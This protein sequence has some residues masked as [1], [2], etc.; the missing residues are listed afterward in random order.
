LVFW[1][2]FADQLRYIWFHLLERLR[3]IFHFLLVLLLTLR[4]IR[5][6]LTFL[7]SKC[8]STCFWIIEFAMEILHMPWYSV[9]STLRFQAE[10]AL[11]RH[12]S[13]EIMFFDWLLLLFLVVR[14]LDLLVFEKFLKLQ[15]YVRRP[16]GWFKFHLTLNLASKALFPKVWHLKMIINTIKFKYKLI[17]LPGHERLMTGNI[18]FWH[19]SLA[20]QLQVI[21][22]RPYLQ[23]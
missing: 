5:Y 2:E 11:D 21:T 19:V 20:E 9:K 1:E 17:S 23:I 16:I 3:F 10:P 7:R 4:V 18:N 15:R 13:V 12:I 14:H 6:C 22:S 8:V